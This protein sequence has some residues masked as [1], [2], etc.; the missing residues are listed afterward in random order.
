[1]ND[2][3]N[4]LLNLVSAVACRAIRHDT[5]VPFDHIFNFSSLL[6]AAL[7]NDFELI[8]KVKNP[9]EVD[10]IL[11]SLPIRVS[12]IDTEITKLEEQLTRNAGVS[13]AQAKGFINKLMTERCVPLELEAKQLFELVDST[14]PIIEK[15]AR[16]ILK[17]VIG[18]KARMSSLLAF[19]RDEFGIS[20]G[21]NIELNREARDVARITL[22]SKNNFDEKFKFFG[23]AEARA[24]RPLIQAIFQNIYQ[25]GLRYGANTKNLTIETKF[26]EGSFSKLASQVHREL[27]RPKPDGNWCRVEISNNGPPI[28]IK[29]V[30]YIFRLGTKYAVEGVSEAE[31][32]GIGMAICYC[33]VT[34]HRGII[35]AEAV[36]SGVK[37]Q[38]FLPADP[39]SGFRIE[40][41]RQFAHDLQVI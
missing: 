13:D 8:K 36:E 4:E 41:L 17:N 15:Y 1:M 25:N 24:S 9:F 28:P 32:H 6:R 29:A 19:F 16:L 35:F 2:A 20:G 34:L 7:S 14:D 30:N 3:R 12:E 22:G 27:E 38:I 39:N 18:A 23:Q 40:Q 11:R 26:F 37:I 33:A 5:R 31:S 10:R 21:A